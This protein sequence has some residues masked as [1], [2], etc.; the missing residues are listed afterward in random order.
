MYIGYVGINVR[1]QSARYGSYM[2]LL[3]ILYLLYVHCEYK[4][5]HL[6]Y[7]YCMYCS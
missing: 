1:A 5:I 4:Y 2:Y 7:I 6:N 3:Y